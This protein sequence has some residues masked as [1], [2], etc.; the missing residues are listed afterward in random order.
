MNLYIHNTITNK[1]ELFTP[2]SKNK[3]INMYVCGPTVYSEPHIGNARAALV[4]DLYFRLLQELY[5][6][7]VYI[8]NLTDVDDKII[9]K[10]EQSG[11]P[12][13]TLTAD[14]IATY[15]SN[16]LSLNMLKPTFEPRVT[17]NIDTIIKT[18][19]KIIINKSA[20]ISAN[21]VVF[22]TTSFEEYGNLSKK[23]SGDLIDGA[24]I[25]PEPYKKNPKDFILWKPSTDNKYGWD[26][27][28][29]FG[30]PGWHIECTSM[31]KSIIG[32]NETL[33]IHGG[34]NDLIF[35]HHENEIAQGSCCSSSKYCNY[36]FHNGIVLVDKKK[37]SKSLGNVILVSGIIAEHNPIVVR[38]ALMSTHYRQPLNWTENTI[39]NAKNIL[40]KINRVL[41][42]DGNSDVEKDHNFIGLLCDD[43]NTP[44]AIQYLVK[45]AKEAKNNKSSLHKLRYNCQLLGLNKIN[46]EITLSDDDRIKI[47]NLISKRD[48]A[49]KNNDYEQA[50]LIRNQLESMHVELE[51]S[52]DGVTWKIKS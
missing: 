23:I 1:K 46:L 17:D 26:S 29:G 2:C 48:T 33:D 49:R 50:D 32:D 44:N 41:S 18:I 10:S 15:Q 45:Q 31:I 22:D 24:R 27:P 47:E 14:T 7:V 52:P 11:I 51:D 5:D 43:I 34:G 40:D 42:D 36:W 37:M 28:W 12:I 4:G 21:H 13:D 8:R 39:K 16:M 3:K 19:E 38:L 6:N 9:D 35:P 30:R 20:Y 25:T